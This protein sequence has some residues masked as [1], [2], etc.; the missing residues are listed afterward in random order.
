[1]SGLTAFVRVN[2]VSM[3]GPSV[4]PDRTVLV[5]NGLIE[6]IEEAA[7]SIP[8]RDALVIDGR[9]MYLM[10]GL[11]DM[12]FHLGD[13]PDD[14]SLLLVN[15]V[16][17]IRNMWGIEGFQLRRWALGTR[18]FRHLEL[19]DG[20]RDGLL[21]GPA[22]YSAGPIIEGNR[23]FF[24]AFMVRKVADERDALEAVRSQSERGYDLIKFYQTV[25]PSPFAALVRAAKAASLPIAGHVP[26]SV[27]LLDTI[28]A[29]VTSIEHLFGFF[30]PYDPELALRK[31]AW[32][33]AAGL[34]AEGGVF[35]CPTLI[36][37]ERLCNLP[38]AERYESEPEMA[39]LPRRVK[40]GM[41][42][43]AGVSRDLLRRKGLKPNHEYLPDLFEAVRELKRRGAGILLGTDKAVP[44][45]VAGFS[46]HREMH[47][48]R[49][50]GLT[51]YEVLR[52]GTADAARCLGREEEVGTVEAGKRADLI[53]LDRNPLEE[54]ETIRCHRGVMA[55]GRFLDRD[56]CRRMLEGIRR[57]STP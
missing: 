56:A 10:P 51:P 36:A 46:L 21:S 2:V 31:T 43:L 20:I 44:Y 42:F 25:R 29:G 32:S 19:R 23:P 28:R 41:R 30:N 24:P 8:P 11:I 47:L 18:V 45:V 53:L 4:E 52:A 17:S 16:T 5:R 48:L 38:E 37:S 40:R 50:A 14:L 1:M 3:R 33:E 26:D 57:R 9:G 54:P 39:Y 6:S 55:R 49:D 13:N 22:I 34:C 15:G 27:G 35:N 12:H 7:R